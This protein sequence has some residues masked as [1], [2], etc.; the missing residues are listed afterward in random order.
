MKESYFRR[1][2]VPASD[3]TKMTLYISRHGD[4]LSVMGILQDPV[5][6]TEPYVLSRIFKLMP[7]DIALRA[8]SN[9]CVPADE[10]SELRN[11]HIPQN[12]PGQNPD[13]DGM[14]KQFNVPT[15]A[16]LG[17]RRRCIGVSKDAHQGRLRAV[18]DLLHIILL[19]MAR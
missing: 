3:H 14:L 7:T 10:V 19:R 4:L 5:Y 6:L 18:E 9:P 12:L 1:N 17:G 11:H 16:A 15:A 8:V 2:G 13:L